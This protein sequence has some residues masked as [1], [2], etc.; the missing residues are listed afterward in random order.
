MG[1]LSF[2]WVRF[3]PLRR[4]I[5]WHF[6]RSGDILCAFSIDFLNKIDSIR[7]ET[8]SVIKKTFNWSIDRDNVKAPSNHKRLQEARSADGSTRLLPVMCRHCSKNSLPSMELHESVCCGEKSWNVHGG[9][10]ADMFYARRIYADRFYA[11][12]GFM[13]NRGFTKEGQKG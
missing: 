9:I 5:S 13:Q 3:Q 10:Y 12:S 6:D 7:R 4:T 2:C 1:E 8:F 11:R